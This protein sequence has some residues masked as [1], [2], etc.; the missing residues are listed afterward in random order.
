MPSTSLSFLDKD[1]PWYNGRVS[2]AL[3]DRLKARLTGGTDSSGIQYS[4][5][6]RLSSADADKIIAKMKED[7]RG[8]PQVDQ[9][10]K[11]GGY[12]NL[13]A[14]Q[15]WLVEEYL[16]SNIPPGLDE[17][18][19][20]IREEKKEIKKEKKPTSSALVPVGTKGTDLVEEQVD[21]RI[22]SILG[23]QDAFDFTYEEYLTLL[24]EKMVAG[25]M[26][27]QSMPTESVELVTDEYKRIKGK[28]GKFKV[29][30]KK[31][32]IDK[33]VN[34]SGQSA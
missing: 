21:E 8:Y 4:S 2:D 6:V 19:S 7:P 30:S 15:N 16:E 27:K 12:S 11:D 31:I 13:E 32:N 29:K 24:K 18:L 9:K 34:R 22:L 1:Q 20:E 14:Y 26:A 25:R 3:W 17:V 23:L 10:G 28:S 5:F 33:V